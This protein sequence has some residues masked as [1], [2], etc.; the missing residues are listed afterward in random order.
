MIRSAL[1]SSPREPDGTIIKGSEKSMPTS[2]E[3]SGGQEP[4]FLRHEA[5]AYAR[6]AL[7][8]ILSVDNYPAL[9]PPVKQSENL[10]DGPI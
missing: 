7:N 8:T 9:R 4:L 3:Q 6:A 2:T 10:H 1:A 5:Q